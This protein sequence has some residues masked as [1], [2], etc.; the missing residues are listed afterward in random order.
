MTSQARTT[1]CHSQ[2]LVKFVKFVFFIVR[3]VI[4]HMFQLEFIFKKLGP[5]LLTLSTTF[6]NVSV[7]CTLFLM[8]EMRQFGAIGNPSI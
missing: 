3:R 2:K 5:D 8:A 7:L 1:R 6:Y 4:R